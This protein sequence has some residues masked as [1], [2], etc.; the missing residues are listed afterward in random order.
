[1]LPFPQTFV[2]LLLLFSIPSIFLA[3]TIP[4]STSQRHPFILPLSP[5]APSPLSTISLFPTTMNSTSTFMAPLKTR[6]WAVT[7]SKQAW[8]RIKR[9]VSPKRNPTSTSTDPLAAAVV[10][11]IHP[12]TSGSTLSQDRTVESNS[13]TTAIAESTSQPLHSPRSPHPPNSP[14]SQCSESNA[15][16]TVQHSAMFCSGQAGDA[17]VPRNRAQQ[18]KDYA[19]QRSS[20]SSSTLPDTAPI[21]PNT[22]ITRTCSSKLR[23]GAGRPRRVNSRTKKTA[24][25]GSRARL[26]PLVKRADDENERIGQLLVSCGREWPAM[27]NPIGKINKV[28]GVRLL[29]RRRRRRRLWV[30]D[31]KTGQRL[32]RCRSWAS[33]G[34]SQ[35][36]VKGRP[37]FFGSIKA[38]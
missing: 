11:D 9:A 10:A 28:G 1:M 29:L 18:G 12:T 20:S 31:A 19:R 32:G 21:Y 8:N 36:Y 23:R 17:S 14:T 6:S 33:G 5:I 24:Q 26:L 38:I 3:Y 2:F 30:V 13:A 4:A 35:A 37:L 7:A 16:N 34:L 25:H 15:R 27:G 22:S